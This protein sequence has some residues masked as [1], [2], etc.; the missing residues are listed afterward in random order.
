MH[1]LPHPL[2]AS[3]RGIIVP[4]P[5]LLALQEAVLKKSRSWRSTALTQVM[6]DDTPQM[7]VELAVHAHTLL[8]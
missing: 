4:D 2:A 1:P 8:H 5:A 7:T 3:S 6:G